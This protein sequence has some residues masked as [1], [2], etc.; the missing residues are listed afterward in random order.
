MVF[1]KK[2]VSKVADS[3]FWYKK[4]DLTLSKVGLG[5]SE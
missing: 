2:A 5:F 1:S 3:L 4:T